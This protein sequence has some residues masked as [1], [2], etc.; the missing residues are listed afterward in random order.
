MSLLVRGELGILSNEWGGDKWDLCERRLL[1][2]GK[3]GRPMLCP[4][5]RKH[6][7][8]IVHN[9]PYMLIPTQ[10]LTQARPHYSFWVPRE[11]KQILCLQV[12]GCGQLPKPAA[13]QGKHHLSHHLAPNRYSK[14]IESR[15]LSK[16][17]WLE[18][19][20]E[21]LIGLVGS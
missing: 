7:C 13:I 12:A 19:L 14:A 10:A 21:G 5:Y 15:E 4:P 17:Q 9:S 18:G 2:P 6:D 8:I 1:V 11:R 16:G 20:G 3:E